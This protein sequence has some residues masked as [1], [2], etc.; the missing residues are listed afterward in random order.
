[1][2]RL[3]CAFVVRIW[4]KQGFSW[5]GSFRNSMFAKITVAKIYVEFYLPYFHPLIYE[6]PHD[7]TN[8]MTGLES[9]LSAWRKLGSL[10]THWAHSEDTDQT[11]RMPRLIRVFAGRTVS[12]LVL[13]WGGSYHVS[14]SP[15]FLSILCCSWII[16]WFHECLL[17]MMVKTL[18]MLDVD[19]STVKPV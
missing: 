16:L 4:H 9:S 19:L 14:L 11:G 1:M 15:R 17:T 18:L 2:R 8:K 5:H 6:P 7:K 13:S 10:A 12:L 3:I